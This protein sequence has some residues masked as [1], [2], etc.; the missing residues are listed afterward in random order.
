MRNSINFKYSIFVFVMIIHFS[1]GL[2]GQNALTLS[3]SCETGCIDLTIND[4]F[5]PYDV[6]W[7]NVDDNGNVTT[8]SDMSGVTGEEGN[9]DLCDLQYSGVYRVVV[10]DAFCGIA[11]YEIEVD[12]CEC[13]DINLIYLNNVQDCWDDVHSSG[14]SIG[15][16]V[17]GA[18]NYTIQWSNG[19]TGTDINKLGPGIYTVTVTSG[20]CEIVRTYQICCCHVHTETTSFPSCNERETAI[21]DVDIASPSSSSSNDGYIRLIL[22]SARQITWYDEN[23]NQ[24]G[25]GR[26]LTGL[27]PG[28]YCVQISDGCG[29]YIS[30]C[31]ELV[32]CTESTLSVSGSV[33]NTCEGFE[34]GK[35][36]ISVVGG[37]TPY[38]FK[39]SNGMTTEDVQNLNAGTYCVTI[40]DQKYCTE[41]ACFNVG[42]NNA[43]RKN[44]R[45]T[46]TYECNGEI[47]K[48]ENFEI[49]RRFTTAECV[50]ILECSNG[51]VISEDVGGS[52]QWTA[53]CNVI[54]VCNNGRSVFVQSGTINDIFDPENCVRH[55]ICSTTLDGI[56]Y[57]NYIGYIYD[58]EPCI[59]FSSWFE[60]PTDCA[61]IGYRWYCPRTNQYVSDE[62]ETADCSLYWRLPKCPDYF[63]PNS[64]KPIIEEND[65]K[66]DA[67]EGIN[68]SIPIVKLIE[69]KGL[70]DEGGLIYSDT[71]YSEL[72]VDT[73]LNY[74]EFEVKK[75]IFNVKE[76]SNFGSSNNAKFLEDKIFK[77]TFYGK[78][79]LSF[80]FM[81]YDLSGAKISEG[82]FSYGENVVDLSHLK[83]GFF[84]I[85][86]TDGKIVPKTIKI[87]IP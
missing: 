25:F 5:A 42:Y 87:F 10:K 86:Y 26:N 58:A 21:L 57:S 39:W 68:S 15:I 55:R 75:R 78:E 3:F 20:P 54:A 70:P 12:P 66:M 80:D 56:Y 51:E 33:T 82:N 48:T 17:S 24:I 62:I 52:L 32:D 16:S 45:C 43:I 73:T 69:K 85:R 23:G 41:T 27:G 1:T 4:G 74:T 9:E 13:I 40:T 11:E 37:D 77:L 31:W 71:A 30:E 72:V 67:L 22:S 65:Y 61:S 49:L 81:I 2:V 47:V 8:I 34:V 29:D 76:K 19:S 63:D 44:N 46:V 6:E 83:S 53:E 50:E 28:I 84:F 60:Y 18:Q 59:S 35:I 79:N 38:R 7:Q 36:N 14:G 64:F